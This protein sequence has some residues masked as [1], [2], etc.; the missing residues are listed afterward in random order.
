MSVSVEVS[1][2]QWEGLVRLLADNEMA[3]L[4]D[5]PRS[6]SRYEKAHR[7][8]ENIGAWQVLHTFDLLSRYRRDA[9]AYATT[10]GRTLKRGKPES[11]LDIRQ[12]DGLHAG[13]GGD[14]LSSPCSN[15]P[16]AP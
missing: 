6:L 1:D 12:C 5:G 9:Q 10:K 8:S 7:R 16:D 3:C 13:G 4:P 15:A 14:E 11:T 2:D